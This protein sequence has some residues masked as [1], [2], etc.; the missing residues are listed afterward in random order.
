MHNA[1]V[2][3][4]LQGH[5]GLADVA[6]REIQIETVRAGPSDQRAQRLTRNQLHDQV[7]LA[8]LLAVVE[9]RGNSRMADQRRGARLR[10]EPA[11]EAGV[12]GQ[13]GAQ[14]LGRDPA[15]EQLVGG[16]P[17]LAHAATRDEVGQPIAVAEQQVGCRC[18]R[19]YASM[20][21]FA[22]G[23][24]SRPPLMSEGSSR[25]DSTTTATAICGSSAG[26]KETNHA[27]GLVPSPCCAVPVLPATSM[28]GIC[29]FWPVPFSTTSIIMVVSWLATSGEIAGWSGIG[30]GFASYT[31][32]RSGPRTS[33]TRYGC[34]TTP[35][36]A[37]PAAII[38]ACSGVIAT[39][40]WPIADSAVCGWSASSG[41]MLVASCIGKS[42]S[43]LSPKRSAV[44]FSLSAPRSS[45]IAPNAVLQEIR[46]ALSSVV[47]L[48]GPHGCPS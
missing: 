24:A 19:R 29:A 41:K 28:P 16:A 7:G 39:S 37:T 15:V 25:P 43:W 30:F 5:R 17:Y 35:P 48:L 20:T 21:D 10:P 45:P 2:V 6:Q 23:A 27:C 36:F 1:R 14:H 4:R 34:M 32:V 40:N 3:G 12:A 33:L 38:A 8:L 9:E 13:L 42:R 44:A 31:V 26:A 18:H 11:E 46:S 47:R 22:I